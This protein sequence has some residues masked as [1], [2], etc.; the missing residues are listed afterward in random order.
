MSEKIGVREDMGV[1]ISVDDYRRAAKRRLPRPV[2]DYI[3]GGAEKELTV[4]ENRRAFDAVTFRPRGAVEVGE[5]DLQVS[6]LGETLSM[7][8]L[9][10]PCGAATLVHSS[11]DVA[12][13]RA[14]GRAGTAFVLS[15][16]SGHR[17]EEV[18]AAAG[19]A[20]VWYQ[21]YRVGGYD[22]VRRSID[23]AR[24]AGVAALVVTIDSAVPSLRER[25]W[26]NGGMALLS[27]NKLRST[28]HAGSLMRKPRWFADHMVHGFRPTVMNVT[29]EHG[30]P[31]RFGMAPAVTGL[32]W[33]DLSFVRERFDGP[34]IV[35]G[36]LTREDAIR[37]ADEGA[38]AVIVSNHGGRQ[39]D[40]A[41]ATLRVLPEVAAAVGSRCEVLLD[42]GARSG[43]DV[44]KALSLGAKAVL[45][46]R[47]WLYGLG[48][49]GETGIDGVLELFQEGL[50]RNLPLLGASKVSDLSR[51][52][53]RIPADWLAAGEPEGVTT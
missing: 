6:V 8:V 16:M 14:A 9:L 28:P 24:D 25:D 48:A 33:R 5:I 36:V 3:D 1:L 42:S 2:F 45:V 51:S 38:A 49:R 46:G 11:G 26:R 18:V 20:P 15:T 41:D 34:I 47:P 37:S 13:A 22:D 53:V 44:M 27:P 43:I 4:G 50:R 23:R 32:V 39:L 7:P 31:K 17:V 12:G 21:V 40:A 52:F 19:G 29:D 35:K 10:A 30:V